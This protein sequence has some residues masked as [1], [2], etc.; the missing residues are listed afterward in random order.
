MPPPNQPPTSPKL[1]IRTYGQ[2][3]CKYATEMVFFFVLL[4]S[5]WFRFILSCFFPVLLQFAVVLV[6]CSLFD[7][8]S[9]Q[10]LVFFS[11]LCFLFSVFIVL[12]LDCSKRSF[13]LKH[14]QST[15]SSLFTCRRVL[16]RCTPT[17]YTVSCRI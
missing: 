10:D 8:R 15:I 11:P 3:A 13:R 5:V 4:C 16:L 9:P 12:P 6:P 7:L 1:R 17:M 14:L 2:H